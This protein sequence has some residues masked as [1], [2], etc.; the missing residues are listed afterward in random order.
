M[1][2]GSLA[3]P[4]LQ[5]VPR[6]SES[7]CTTAA[8]ITPASTP[9]SIC[10][11]WFIFNGGKHPCAYIGLAVSIHAHLYLKPRFEAAQVVVRRF[12]SSVVPGHLASFRCNHIHPVC[13]VLFS[14]L[15]L[16][17][18]LRAHMHIG[19][20]LNFLVASFYGRRGTSRMLRPPY[21]TF[22]GMWLPRSPCGKPQASSVRNI[23]SV[24]ERNHRESFDLFLF[25]EF[26]LVRQQGSAA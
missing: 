2:Q 25:F 20:N 8:Q 4:I 14:C 5:L 10:S 6:A 7:C 9:N 18:V 24:C 22:S 17:S 16:L 21:M 15:H 1:L 23:P 12:G 26:V 3:A 19:L 11:A 13:L